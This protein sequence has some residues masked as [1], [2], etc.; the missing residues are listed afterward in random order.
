[1]KRK[2]FG[3]IVVNVA[4]IMLLSFI[5]EGMASYIYLTHDLMTTYYLA[6]RRHA[7]H[8]ANLGWVNQPNIYIPDMYG[9]GIY[10]RTNGQGFRNNHEFSIRVPTTKSRII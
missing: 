9:S 3:L 10:L 1:M 7:K 6:E 4:L 5:V 2:L 8:D